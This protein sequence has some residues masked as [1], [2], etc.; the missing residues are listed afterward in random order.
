LLDVAKG[1]IHPLLVM[2]GHE[3]YKELR[4]FTPRELYVPAEARRFARRRRGLEF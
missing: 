2:G 3:V 1:E 4:K